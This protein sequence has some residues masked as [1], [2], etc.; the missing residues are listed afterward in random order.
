MCND[1]QAQSNVIELDAD[2]YVIIPPILENSYSAAEVLLLKKNVG[3]WQMQVVSLS[4]SPIFSNELRIGGASPE[5]FQTIH[6]SNGERYT[7]ILMPQSR[8][9]NPYTKLAMSLWKAQVAPG[10]PVFLNNWQGSLVAADVLLSND[11]RILGAALVKQQTAEQTAF[12]IQKW[13]LNKNDELILMTMPPLLWNEEWTIEHAVIRVNGEGVPFML[14]KGGPESRW[15]W[16]DDAGDIISLGE[17]SSKI[18]LPADIIFV[19]NTYPT[20]LYT[21]ETCG[22]KFYS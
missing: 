9:G 3:E 16:M 12:V 18:N 22:L 8:E 2:D 1:E 17:F 10:K 15:F 13:Q 6:R 20:I 21:D 11:D 4:H 14:L 7:F 5:W 19:S